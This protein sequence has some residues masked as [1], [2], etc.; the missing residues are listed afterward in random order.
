MNKFLVRCTVSNSNLSYDF[1]CVRETENNRLSE[2][3]IG[4][5]TQEALD[6]CEQEDADVF[7]DLIYKLEV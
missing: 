1:Q 7:F 4:E 3:D 5:I 6:Y 2:H